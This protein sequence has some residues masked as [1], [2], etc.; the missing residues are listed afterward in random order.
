MAKN[1][2]IQKKTA[3]MLLTRVLVPKFKIIAIRY[4]FA[5][6]CCIQFFQVLYPFSVF[7]V[8]KMWC[9]HLCYIQYIM[10][11]KVIIAFNMKTTKM[12]VALFV[13][14]PYIPRAKRQKSSVLAKLVKINGYN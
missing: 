9:I 3:K 5:K 1:Y 7:C 2:V 4:H 14:V 11:K 10:D 13:Y 8:L 12:G 6:I